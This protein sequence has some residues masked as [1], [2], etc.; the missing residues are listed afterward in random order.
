MCRRKLESEIL[1]HSQVDGKNEAMNAQTPKEGYFKFSP[2]F[3][4]AMELP[5]A[6]LTELNHWRDRLFG[7]KLVGMYS[8]GELKGVG[9]GNLSVR[10]P[11]GFFIT[12]TRTGGLA[13]LG[14]DHYT[15]IVRVDLA[16]NAVDYKAV[17]AI[18]T[19]SSECMTHAMFYEADPGVGAVMHVH[20]LDF[21]KR[22][23]GRVPTTSPEVEYGTPEMALEISRLYRETDLPRRKL[24]AMAGHEE[25][26]IA[27]GRDLDEAGAVL[28]EAFL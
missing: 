13:T 26:V 15:E 23:L 2:T 6:A 8:E 24:V 4:G 5:P 19:P 11:G 16:C 3:V 1:T 28:L 22:L 20:H 18:T 27:F 25:G 17:S 10:S 7:L 21:W 14:I 9:Y 12:A